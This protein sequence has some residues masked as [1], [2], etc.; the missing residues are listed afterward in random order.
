MLSEVPH[1]LGL[2]ANKPSLLIQMLV[3]QE[4]QVLLLYLCCKCQLPLANQHVSVDPEKMNSLVNR[5][6]NA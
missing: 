1:S 2:I 6:K 4:N 5:D 3:K